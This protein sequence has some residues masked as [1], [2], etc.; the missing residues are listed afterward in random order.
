MPTYYVD[1][2]SVGGDGTTTGL[3]GATAAFALA[4]SYTPVTGDTVKLKRGQTHTT[5]A[6]MNVGSVNSITYTSYY[7]SD[8]TDDISIAKPILITSVTTHWLFNLGGAGPA[9][10]IEWKNLDL[11][12]ISSSTRQVIVMS[13]SSSNWVVDNC[14]LRGSPTQTNPMFRSTAATGGTMKNTDIWQPNKDVHGVHI[15]TGSHNT[16][17][18]D[19]VLILDATLDR[20][21]STNSGC[22]QFNGADNCIV[23]R[24]KTRNNITSYFAD[25][26]D[27]NLR[28]QHSDT[29]LIPKVTDS[30]IFGIRFIDSDTC[31]AYDNDIRYCHDQENESGTVQGVCIGLEGSSENC[32]IYSNFLTYGGGCI[33]DLT[34]SGAS[35]NKIYGNVAINGITGCIDIRNPSATP[36]E[37]YNNLMINLAPTANAGMKVFVSGGGVNAQ[38]R[39][40]N[41][42]FMNN[43]R[44][45]TQ[46][47]GGGAGE[48]GNACIGFGGLS[49]YAEVWSDYNLFISKNHDNS[50]QYNPG[51]A[52]GY[53]TLSSYQVAAD[54][55]DQVKGFGGGTAGADANS[56]HVTTS[57]D[58][59][60]YFISSD[61]FTLGLSSVTYR[62]YHPKASTSDIYHAGI[63]V[64]SFVRD[65]YGRQFYRAGGF[66]R[67]AFEFGS[68]FRFSAVTRRKEAS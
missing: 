55:D 3:T 47:A 17:I 64:A 2:D 58:W 68:G 32:K 62:N 31:E 12:L 6:Q 53:I 13:N 49:A 59:S 54:A 34:A 15:S 19:C 65:F 46:N 63:R 1:T 38:A 18:E 60:D 44:L 67:G 16:T 50:F 43:A 21:G 66:S 29:L 37:V 41:N 24:N 5:T 25:V 52:T 7:N 27:W 33:E 61:L 45:T 14:I 28:N 20:S 11:R 10:G 22:V 4:N 51:T 23:R 8:G 57:D 30:P 26:T 56:V 39:I 42:I 40:Y 36:T 48:T 9:T 35:G